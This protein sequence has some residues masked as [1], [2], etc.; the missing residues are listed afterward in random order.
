ML[1]I[2]VN[3]KHIRIALHYSVLKNQFIPHPKQDNKYIRQSNAKHQT[4]NNHIDRKIQQAKDAVE[5]LEKEKKLISAKHI[6]DR[7]ALPT[8]IFEFF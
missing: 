3:H 6:K 5:S 8:Y 7:M 4:I 1:R 2:T